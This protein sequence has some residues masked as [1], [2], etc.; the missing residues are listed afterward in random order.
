MQAI[1]WTSSNFSGG[2]VKVSVD[3]FNQGATNGSGKAP[4][5]LFICSIVLEIKIKR[6]RF[7]AGLAEINKTPYFTWFRISAQPA[8]MVAS[9]TFSRHH[10]IDLD[11][12]VG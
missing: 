1:H 5:Q 4:D 2:T 11:I 9:C 3:D 12:R 10:N 7:I 6:V 8:D